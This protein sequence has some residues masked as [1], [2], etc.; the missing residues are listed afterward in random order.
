LLCGLCGTF[1]PHVNTFLGIFVPLFSERLREQRDLLDL[2]QQAL[3]D[4][5]GIAA[6]SQRNYESGE[7]LPDAA[8][9]TALVEVGA[10]VLY[11]LTGKQ[12]FTPPPTLSAEEQTLLDYFRQASKEVRRAA[13]G[14][15]LGASA[16]SSTGGAQ[17][18]FHGAVRGDIVGRDKIN[19]R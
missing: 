4:R 13:L 7:R 11:I 17:Q 6:R 5:C 8:Y 15:L 18:V 9:L 16:P 1:V 19:K 12:N 14:A 3:A 2:S 10:D